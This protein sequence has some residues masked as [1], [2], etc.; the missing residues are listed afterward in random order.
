MQ[1]YYL[2]QAGKVLIHSFKCVLTLKKQTPHA[3]N[4][5]ARTLECLVRAGKLQPKENERLQV[6]LSVSICQGESPSLVQEIHALG[7][8]TVRSPPLL[9]P[10]K[11]FS[12][13]MLKSSI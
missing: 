5:Q 7:K 3:Y 4:K 6:N 1:I 11:S 2:N 13:S 12:K 9:S 10:T 8:N